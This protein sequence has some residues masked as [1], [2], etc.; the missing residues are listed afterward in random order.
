MYL[1]HQLFWKAIKT[2]FSPRYFH[3]L[4]ATYLT[5][6]SGGFLGLHAL[7]SLVRQLETIPYSQ[8][9][10]QAITAPIYITGNPRSGTTFLH[11]LLCED[12]QFTYTK[13]YHTIF[14]SISF[15]HLFD[16][17]EKLN[18]RL[19]GLFTPIINSL[20]Q[21]SF[22]GWDK[23]HRTKLN[24]AEEDE[25]FFVFTM[26]SPVITLLFP[27]FTEL[28]E[29]CWVDRLPYSTREQLMLHYCDC[30]RRH[31]Y[32]TGGDK[33][34]LIKNTTCTGR[35][36]TMLETIPD[37]KVIHLIRHPYQAIP[38]LL[39]MYNASWNTFV[40]Q[41]KHNSVAS[42]GLAQLYAD[43]YGQRVHILQKLRQ[44]QPERLIEVRYEDLT[45]NTL[46]VIEQI[47]EQFQLSLTA[48]TLTN[49]KTQIQASQKSYSSKHKYS[50]EQ[51]GLSK[52]LIYNSMP[53]VFTEY[54]FQP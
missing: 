30:L 45:T 46:T 19:N 53:D 9:R 38:S 34:L 25:Q 52:E 15:Y 43:Y 31:L 8:Y 11:R 50:L 1:N 28:T 16:N 23:I 4:H 48:E 5:L 6:F 13:L 17:L 20:E 2:S 29:S 36:E 44:N 27:F 18:N 14:P 3:P 47:Y 12:S 40:P 10:N 22:R 37:L 32:A 41:V 24:Q 49:F 42:Q 54:N 21:G 39:S 26:L 7:V 33:T 35:L 51:F